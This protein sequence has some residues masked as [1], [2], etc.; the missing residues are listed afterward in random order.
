M[1]SVPPSSGPETSKINKSCIH[2]TRRTPT[3]PVPQKPQCAPRAKNSVSP[4]DCGTERQRGCRSCAT[5]K[6]A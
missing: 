3:L 1:P 5:S 4:H 2:Q 6:A